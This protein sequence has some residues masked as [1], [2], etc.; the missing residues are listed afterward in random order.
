M[1]MYFHFI[2]MKIQWINVIIDWQT[3]LGTDA[4]R[5]KTSNKINL[6]GNLC[7]QSKD[8]TIKFIENG[9]LWVK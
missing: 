1:G 8:F 2:F 4:K 3:V 6:L 7:N 9:R 5:I